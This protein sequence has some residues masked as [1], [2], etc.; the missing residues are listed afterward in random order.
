MGQ[1]PEP[2]QPQTPATP[3]SSFQTPFVVAEPNRL[4][5][6]PKLDGE[7]SDEEWDPLVSSEVLKGYLQWEPGLLHFAATVP[8]GQDVVLSLDMRANGWLVGNDNL[9]IRVAAGQGGTPRVTARMVDATNVAGPTW[10]ELPGVSQA[11]VAVAKAGENGTTYEVTISDADLGLFPTSDGKGLAV[12]LDAIPSESAPLAAYIPR[13]LAPVSF[14]YRRAA[15]VPNDLKWGVEGA[16]HI[17]LPGNSIRIRYTFNGS[18]K[19]GLKKLSLRSEGWLKDSTTQTSVPFPIFDNKGRAFVDY[20]TAIRPDATV[21]Y[22][23]SRGELEAGDGLT[24]LI[25]SSYRVAPVVDLELVRQEIKSQPRDQR[26]KVAYHL[27]SNSP[28]R[29]NG[30]VA[31]T[32]PTGF[33][34]VSNQSKEFGIFNARGTNRRV[35]EMD[36]PANAKGVYPIQVRMEI[37]G[38]MTDKT[39]Y[40]NIQ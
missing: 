15:A 33:H 35:L 17:V 38:Q 14:T 27:K 18:D 25:Q 24:A 26:V 8:S 4:A 5:L 2:A 40:L 29:V 21:G 10:V 20:E 28:R 13:V 32:L 39:F 30:T 23:I 37:G 12:R 31:V 36:I 34:L 16:G 11:A 9:E 3:E 1:E 6:T 19:L 7:L 22:R